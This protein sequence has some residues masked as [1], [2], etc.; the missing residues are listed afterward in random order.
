[1]EQ[2]F[3]DPIQY[4]KI[5]SEGSEWKASL[6]E[7]RKGDVFSVSHIDGIFGNELLSNYRLINEKGGHW[8]ELEKS[9]SVPVKKQVKESATRKTERIFDE[10]N[11]SLYNLA[12][13]FPGKLKAFFENVIDK[14]QL[15]ET[16]KLLG[17]SEDEAKNLQGEFLF[18]RI[19]N[20]EYMNVGLLAQT[21]VVKL[22]KGEKRH[23]PYGL[24]I[25]FLERHENKITK[26]QEQILK[27]LEIFKKKI[28]ELLREKSGKG[29]LPIPDDVLMERLESLKIETLDDL[30]AKLSERWGDYVASTHTIRVS[31]GV[32]E[33]DLED[34]YVHEIMHAISGQIEEREAT[35]ESSFLGRNILKSGVRCHE[36]IDSSSGESIDAGSPSFSWLNEALTEQLT[37]DL[38]E[39]KDSSHYIEERALLKKLL[40]IGI[41]IEMFKGAYFENYKDRGQGQHRLPKTKELFSFINNNF[42]GGF[43]VKLDLYITR[44]GVSQTLKEWEKQGS[45]FPAFLKSWVDEYYKN[46]N[47]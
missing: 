11:N 6:A 26:K 42:G 39:L 35:D 36:K 2:D 32:P 16:I 34:I 15:S 43:L 22:A 24:V 28:V 30:S 46:L 33:E 17:L 10:F 18:N 4:K 21:I 12:K 37:I 20:K 41:S 31:T 3:L 47:Q 29:I 5:S 13:K 44:V 1:M 23:M 19:Y 25:N 27:K 45:E 8:E 40:S 38:L 9:A 14:K 7:E